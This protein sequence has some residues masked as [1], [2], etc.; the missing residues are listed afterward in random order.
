MEVAPGIHRIAS[1]LGPRPFSQYLLLDERSLLFDTGV[2]ETP[3][4]VILPFLD[5]LQP[6]LVLNS[7]ADVDHFGGNAAIRAAAPRAVFLAH[8]LDV[9]WIESADTIMRERYGWYAAHGLPYDDDVF[10]WLRDAMGPDM[11]IDVH[12]RGGE[13]IRLGPKLTVEVLHLPGHSPGHLGLWDPVSRTAIVMDAV[14]GRGLLNMD[15]TVIHP[16]PYFDVEGYLG[17]AR[18]LQTLAPERLLTAHYDVIEGAEV[19]RFLAETIAFVEDARRIVEEAL[20]DAGTLTLQQALDIAD[21]QL[22]PFTSMRNELAGSLRAHL[23]QLVAE[24]RAREE[25]S[26]L[27]WTSVNEKGGT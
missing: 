6:D 5:G 20:A 14:M 22:G 11:P 2:K 13:K 18:R 24:G 27:N 3:G 26:G 9:P 8:A 15:G 19:E 21:P 16:P 10:A 1:I 7:H 12:L 25:A 17:A 23:R 4:E